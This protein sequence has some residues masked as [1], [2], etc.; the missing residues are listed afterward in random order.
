ML[1]WVEKTSESVLGSR[2]CLAKQRL[3]Q[4]R[5]PVRQISAELNRKESQK[6]SK[7]KKKKRSFFNPKNQFLWYSTQKQLKKAETEQF[8]NTINEKKKELKKFQKEDSKRIRP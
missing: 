6:R 4:A 2:L 1:F 7:G 8:I 3:K 5:A